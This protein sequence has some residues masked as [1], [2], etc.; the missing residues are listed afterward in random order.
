MSY[1]PVPVSGIH[2]A[3]PGFRH[4]LIGPPCNQGIKIILL[5]SQGIKS[6]AT[7]QKRSRRLVYIDTVSRIEASRSH[8]IRV[9]RQHWYTAALVKMTLHRNPECFI[10]GI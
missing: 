9:W 8:K 5:P 6:V 3:S 1:P 10:P 2:S 7:V 4:Q